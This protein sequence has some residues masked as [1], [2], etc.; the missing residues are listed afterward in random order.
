MREAGV[1]IITEADYVRV[2]GGDTIRAVDIKTMPYPGFP[3]D[4][5]SAQMMALLSLAEGASIITETVFENRFK[6]VGGAETNAQTSRW[7]AIRPL[8]KVLKASV[9]SLEASDLR[10]GA[11][12]VLALCGRKRHH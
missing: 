9:S 8:S 7:K 4:M 6:H 1:D 3:T 2:Q 11:A 10:A 12:L 5:S